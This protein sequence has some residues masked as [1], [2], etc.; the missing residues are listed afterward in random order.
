MKLTNR[1]G[2]KERTKKKGNFFIEVT[3]IRKV[4]ELQPHQV[5]K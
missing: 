5:L 1:K 4:T 2:K 3:I